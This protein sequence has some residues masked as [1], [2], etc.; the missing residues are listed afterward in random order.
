MIN[1]GQRPADRPT[2][3]TKYL[4]PAQLNVVTNQF[5]KGQK[6]VA[7]LHL[8]RYVRRLP[9]Q[10]QD[11]FN[12]DFRSWVEANAVAFDSPVTADLSF[13]TMAQRESINRKLLNCDKLGAIR[14]LREHIDKLP[15][16]RRES[17]LRAFRNT[18][19]NLDFLT[20]QQWEAIQ[21][22]HTAGDENGAKA[23]LAEYISQ[24]PVN[25][26]EKAA[27][28][29]L[30]AQKRTT[31]DICALNEDQRKHVLS[32]LSQGDK[33]AARQALENFTARNEASRK[34]AG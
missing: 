26:Q 21:A 23:L 11:E 4:T 34:A 9:K 12:R 16:G 29:L 32:K 25:E 1:G 7:I 22:K 20:P 15:K 30:K 10:K 19:P 2:F 31:N 17:V 33:A 13:L 27:Q 5:K 8:R 24:L 28:E 14:E 18:L 3:L 6:Q